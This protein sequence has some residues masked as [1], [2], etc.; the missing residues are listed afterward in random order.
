M[1]TDLFDTFV[2][3][4]APGLDWGNGVAEAL[5][6][7]TAG[8]YNAIEFGAD[9]TGVADSSVAFQAALDAAKA[10]GP[11]NQARARIDI[12]PGNYV[13]DTSLLWT[14]RGAVPIFAHGAVLTYT[15]A[16]FGFRFETGTGA[17]PAN[18][19][20]AVFGGLW[21][22]TN[23]LADGVFLLQDFG[24]LAF[25][26]VETSTDNQSTGWFIRNFLNWTE[27]VQL[28]GCHSFSNKHAI[29]FQDAAESGGTG[30]TSFARTTVN[31][32]FI[33]GGVANEGH[34][35]FSGS[36]YDSIFRDIRG[37]ITADSIVFDFAGG[38][39]TGSTQIGPVGF[40]NNDGNPLTNAYYFRWNATP[41]A[42]NVVPWLIGEFRNRTVIFDINPLDRPE[43][44]TGLMIQD[45]SGFRSRFRGDVQSVTAGSGFIARSPD[46][47]EY[48]ITVPNGGG[49]VTVTAV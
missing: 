35:R 27:R 24:N 41:P 10:T 47:T 23:P 31:H 44:M 12:P 2:A 25:W 42:E 30:T 9:P 20:P 22:A 43:Q 39:G 49:S 18:E 21:K 37:N 29:Y 38:W 16:D 5:N 3:N 19:R 28:Y 32:F 48:R 13:Y 1:P 6:Y 14:G 46:G 40:E 33:T 34:I 26:G 4:Q 8:V 15:G 36:P 11:A 45:G 17:A 7:T